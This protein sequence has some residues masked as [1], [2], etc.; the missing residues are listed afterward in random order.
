MHKIKIK[1]VLIGCSL[2]LFA[3]TSLASP[4][5]PWVDEWQAMAAKTGFEGHKKFAAMLDDPAAI[6]LT[7]D[8]DAFRGYSAR[9]LVAEA[10]IPED[11]KPGMVITKAN[12]A[13]YPWLKEY[14]P[15]ASYDQLMSNDWFKWQEIRI[16]PTTPYSMPKARLEAT[17][18]ALAA[19]EKFSINDKGELLNSKGE[20]ALTHGDALP[21][22]KPKTGAELYWAFLGHGIA[23][24]NLKFKPMVLDACLTSNKIDRSYE[25]HLF[26][27]KMHGR[28]SVPPLGDIK[29]EEGVIEAG[30]VVFLQP[31]DVAG[32]AATRRR[33]AGAD[34][35]DDFR[36]FVPSLRR[37]RVL[38]GSDSQDPMA[39]GFEATWDE[40]RQTW[41]KPNMQD[42]DFK[43]VGESMIL[44]QPEVG[45]AYNPTQTT[46]SRCEI[47]T[48]DLELRP[49]WI[50]EVTDK[51]GNYIYS[52]RRIYIDKEFWYAQYQE[53]YDQEGNLWRVI[54]DSRDMVPATGLW[55]WRNYTHWNVIS[56]R[57]NRIEMFSDWSIIDENMSGLF[58]IDVLRDY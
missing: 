8:W 40:W 28:V 51:T 49:V 55:M 9:S 13:Q 18:N 22:T 54:D 52:K 7:K 31:Y 47:K 57:F 27:Q 11:M 33:Y 12:A 4:D 29:N 21:F 42:F 53:M 46:E 56:K 5:A 45:H 15:K 48:I 50:L 43:I 25:M 2:S 26:W 1:S 37:T 44:S 24:E 35:A 10:G 19:G 6:Q 14:L 23:N 16:V 39:A 41:M 36:A 34:Q 32:L 30:S 38:S 17:K 3:Q 58:D 20:F